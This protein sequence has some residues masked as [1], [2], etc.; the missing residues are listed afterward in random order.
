[1]AKARK[2][3]LGLFLLLGAFAVLLGAVLVTELS[4]GKTSTEPG[5]PVFGEVKIDQVAWIEIKEK[6]SVRLAKEPAGWFIVAPKRYET[7]P[8]AVAPFLKDLVELRAQRTLDKKKR[9][10]AQYGLDKPRGSLA[11]GWGAVTNRLLLGNE[12]TTEGGK[13]AIN[14]TYAMVEGS[15][16]I[17]AVESARLGLVRRDAAFFRDKTVFKFE[18][19][20]LTAF[21]LDYRGA[22]LRFVK[23]DGE[24]WLDGAPKKRADLAKVT[25]FLGDFHRFQV[26][27]F[28]ADATNHAG[29]GFAPGKNSL[30]VTDDKGTRTLLFGNEKAGLTYVA[31]DGS[32]ALFD[33]QNFKFER[34]NKKE[35]DFI[36]GNET[37]TN[38][39][40]G[41]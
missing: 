3:N 30:R 25:A 2:K 19:P 31:V 1:M 23:A 17:M 35:V 15:D 36:A 11:F 22:T 14:V 41:K 40:G 29:L 4:R 27:S 12:F 39:A 28:L 33:A 20:A 13:E 18:R 16:R 8:L 34:L 10:L 7:D 9:D 21:A 6:Q 26:D 5:S 24:W 32:P 37:S 38:T